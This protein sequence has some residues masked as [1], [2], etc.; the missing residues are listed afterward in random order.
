MM[1]TS[2]LPRRINGG[3][4]VVVFTTARP[5]LAHARSQPW[6]PR[7]T[8]RR[9]PPRA[10]SRAA[11]PALAR[12]RLG[13]CARARPRVGPG[14]SSKRARRRPIPRIPPPATPRAKDRW[15]TWRL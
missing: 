14:S 10:S 4:R 11:A 5:Q 3:R 9:S 12:A 8:P 7:P 2:R 13:G 15:A 1:D 6:W